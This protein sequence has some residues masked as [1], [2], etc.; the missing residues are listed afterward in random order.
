LADF[1]ATP[2]ALTPPLPGGS[3]DHR[4]AAGSGSPTD[5][6]PHSSEQAAGEETVSIFHGSIK[7]AGKIRAN[8]LDPTRRPVCVSRDF[9]AAQ[10]ALD[11]HLDAVP[12][13]GGIVESRVPKSV[14]ESALAPLE[15][16][17]RG[18]Y[19]Y[20]LQSTEITLRDADHIE[21]F[22]AFIVK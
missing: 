17:Y 14:F 4:C 11:R 1:L 9:S 5:R 19:P 7:D 18:F 13:L 6:R 15:R 16:P 21:I 22:N 2:L 20:L 3:L 10:D 8:G 12:G